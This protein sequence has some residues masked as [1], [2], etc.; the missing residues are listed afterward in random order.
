MWTLPKAV[1]LINKLN[2][3]LL[4]LGFYLGLTGSVLFKGESNKD[5]DLIL[6]PYKFN[7]VDYQKALVLIKTLTKAYNVYA[8]EH[9]LN[10]SKIVFVMK[11]KDFRIDIFILHRNHINRNDK[12]HT[13]TADYAEIV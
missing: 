5:L 4:K 13:I 11:G 6:Y 3:E 9:E 12:I 7:N 10:D 2:P 1:E 8:V